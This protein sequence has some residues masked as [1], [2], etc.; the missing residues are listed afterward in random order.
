MGMFLTTGESLSPAYFSAAPG[1]LELQVLWVGFQN[2][3]LLTERD[4]HSGEEAVLEAYFDRIHHFFFCKFPVVY[5]RATRTGEIYSHRSKGLC[6]WRA[7][8]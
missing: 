6:V 4:K 3:W 1:W 7:Y 8:I 2:C 5:I